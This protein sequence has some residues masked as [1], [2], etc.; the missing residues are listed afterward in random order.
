MNSG[1]ESLL[2]YLNE[3]ALVIE[4]KADSMNVSLQ[5]S[6]EVS[7]PNFEKEYP[8]IRSHLSPSRGPSIEKFR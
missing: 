7:P 3:S 2:D 4:E 8:T 5:Y 6:E 1:K